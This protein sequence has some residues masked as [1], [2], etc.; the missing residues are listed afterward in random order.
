MTK[1]KIM[2]FLFLQKKKK[3]KNR[4]RASNL[5]WL[6][7]SSS[8]SAKTLYEVKGVSSHSVSP[9]SSFDADCVP[10]RKGGHPVWV[11][12]ESPGGSSSLPWSGTVRWIAADL[13]DNKNSL[14][15]FVFYASLLNKSQPNPETR[16]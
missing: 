13:K 4:H 3:E 11:Y 9:L 6:L 10:V 15:M 1:I 2:T 8:I 14:S 7:D 16:R 5:F 12:L